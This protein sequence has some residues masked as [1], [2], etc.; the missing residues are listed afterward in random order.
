MSGTVKELGNRPAFP[1][2]TLGRVNGSGLTKREWLA[3]MAMQGLLAADSDPGG[4][5]DV[6]RWAR[7]YAEALLSELAQ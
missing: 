5:K 3:G 6:A 1:N 2:S 4:S 7:Q